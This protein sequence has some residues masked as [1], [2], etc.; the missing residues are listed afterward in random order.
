[1]KKYNKFEQ[2]PTFSISIIVNLATSK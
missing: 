2:I 1:M